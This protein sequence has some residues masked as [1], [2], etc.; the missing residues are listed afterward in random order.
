MDNLLT[1]Q[2]V[3]CSGDPRADARD[4]VR[5]QRCFC[6]EQRELGQSRDQATRQDDR[7]GAA[8]R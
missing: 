5:R 3:Q 7:A 6:F 1:L 4:L 2:A 8:P